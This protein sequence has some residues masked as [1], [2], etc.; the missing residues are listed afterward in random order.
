MTLFGWITLSF[1][2]AVV[3]VFGIRFARDIVWNQK[4]GKFQKSQKK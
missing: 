2:G 3:I 1:I 4:L